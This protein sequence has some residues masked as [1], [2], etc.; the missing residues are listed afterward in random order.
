MKTFLDQTYS[1]VDMFLSSCIL[2]NRDVDYSRLRMIT[3]MPWLHSNLMRPTVLGRRVIEC[4]STSRRT[5]SS[6]SF[7]PYSTT[8]GGVASFSFILPL[9]YLSPPSTSCAKVTKTLRRAGTTNGESHSCFT[10]SRIRSIS[11]RRRRSAPSST[12]AAAFAAC[13]CSSFSRR[14]RVKCSSQSASTFTVN[15][16]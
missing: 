6:I 2:L 3:Y 15:I 11:N 5:S 7:M 8:E 1:S 14:T 16:C 13:A 10:S 12:S 9:S 4:F